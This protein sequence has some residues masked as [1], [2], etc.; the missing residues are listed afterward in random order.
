MKTNILSF[1]LGICL[2]LLISAGSQNTSLF[3]IKPA[4]PRSTISINTN[5]PDA[6]INKYSKYGYIL[7]TLVYYNR[8]D[9]IVVME[10]Y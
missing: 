4:S 7:K 5:Q 1:L 2:M 8:V 3:T 9:A 10:K 6:V